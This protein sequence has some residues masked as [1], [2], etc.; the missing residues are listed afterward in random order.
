[1]LWG[2]LGIWVGVEGGVAASVTSRGWV[3][4]IAIVITGDT[5]VVRRGGVVKKKA[6]L[7]EKVADDGNVA[8]GS[9]DKNLKGSDRVLES[10]QGYLAEEREAGRVTHAWLATSFY[11]TVQPDQPLA[12]HM[13]QH[14]RHFLLYCPERLSVVHLA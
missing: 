4:W 8:L 1:M 11:S 9:G 5:S 10:S 6:G 3:M 2:D 13:A 14:T 7:V 12:K